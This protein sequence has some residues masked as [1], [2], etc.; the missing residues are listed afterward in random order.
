MFFF[1]EVLG[2]MGFPG[3]RGFIRPKECQCRRYALLGE[4]PT[5]GLLGMLVG[6]RVQGLGA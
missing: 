5:K 2:L 1:P 4:A 6:F 3:F